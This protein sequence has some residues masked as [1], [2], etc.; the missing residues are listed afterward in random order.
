MNLV[1]LLSIVTDK[2]TESQRDKELAQ[3]NGRVTICPRQFGSRAYALHHCTA[4]FPD[5]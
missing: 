5:R 3:V 4:N 2:K 1:L